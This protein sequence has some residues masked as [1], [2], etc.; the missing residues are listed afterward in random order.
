[1]ASKRSNEAAKEEEDDD[2]R[3]VAKAVHV[4]T[5]TYDKGDA[6]HNPLSCSFLGSRRRLLL[7]PLLLQ[8]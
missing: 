3:V 7:L 1:M 6:L 5:E 2:T 8:R 4:F